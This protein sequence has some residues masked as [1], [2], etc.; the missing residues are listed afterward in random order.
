[1]NWINI[2]IFLYILLETMVSM[3]IMC[4]YHASVT[5]VI[6]ESYLIC[7]SYD[8]IIHEIW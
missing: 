5:F 2:F 7:E 1:M 3:H 8:M 6:L 4:R